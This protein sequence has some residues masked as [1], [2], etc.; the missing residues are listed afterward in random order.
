MG[1]GVCAPEAGLQRMKQ[2]EIAFEKDMMKKFATVKPKVTVKGKV[3][4]EE[5]LRRAAAMSGRVSDWLTNIPKVIPEWDDDPDLPD[6]EEISMIEKRE[7]EKV[8]NDHIEIVKLCTELVDEMAGRTEA[9][10]VVSN[11]VSNVVEIAWSSYKV[12]S[13]FG[14]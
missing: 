10:S 12:E 5:G 9:L 2:L 6:L 1:R 3:D 14:E 11:I 7:M 4:K 13:A 8:E